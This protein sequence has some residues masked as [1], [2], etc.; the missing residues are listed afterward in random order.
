VRDISGQFIDL[1]AWKRRDHFEL[2]R[3]AAQ[4]FSSVTVNVDVTSAWQRRASPG[5]SFFLAALFALI[6]A[7]NACEPLRL[8]ARGDKVWRHDRVG[9]GTTVLRADDTFGFARVDLADTFDDFCRAAKPAIDRVK[10]PTPLRPMYDTDDLVYHSSLPWLRFTS[11]TNAL[12]GTDSIPRIVF[13]KVFADGSAYLMPVGVEVHH[14]LV[15]GL[16]VA[17]MLDAFEAEIARVE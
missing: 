9:I 16:D 1:A 6:R 4:P 13:G 8:R 3:D 5:Q 11:V 7:A 12:H 2:F 17:R 14:A 10:S 15:D